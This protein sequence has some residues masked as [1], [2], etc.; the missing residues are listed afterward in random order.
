VDSR[1]FL[2]LV[3]EKYGGRVVEADN[4]RTARQY[5]ETIKADLIITDLALPG[6]DGAM[7][8]KWLRARPAEKGGAIPAVA[9][10]AFSDLSK[11]SADDLA[12]VAAALNGRP[13]KTLNWRTPAEALDDL[14]RSA[15]HDSV[16]TIP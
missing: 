5:I 3:L 6:E 7:F 11:P 10:T 14:L 12:A 9:V 13:R 16:A 8:L 15:E 2:R 4:V 1:E